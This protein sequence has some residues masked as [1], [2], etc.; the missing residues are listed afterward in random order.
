[1]S[2]D[3]LPL[4]IAPTL[5]TKSQRPKLQLNLIGDYAGKSLKSRNLQL[6]L[7]KNVTSDNDI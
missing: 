5:I 3:L 7:K 4:I 2:T 6:I 1:M